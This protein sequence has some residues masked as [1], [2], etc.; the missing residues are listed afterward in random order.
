MMNGGGKSDSAIVAERPTNKAGQP[1]AEPED[2]RAETEGNAVQQSTRRGSEPGKRVPGAGSHTTSSKTEKEGKFT[3][4][5]HHI[6]PE[7]L[8]A[9]FFQL[10]ENAAPGVDGLTW[11]AYEEGLD[12]KILDLH[13]RLLRA[14]PSRRIYIPKPDG[15]QRPL[16]VAALEDKIVQRATI[17]V[18]NAIYEEGFLGFSYGFR[19]KRGQ[20]DALDAL[21]IGITI[22]KVNFVLD[23]DIRSYADPFPEAPD[24]RPAHNPPDPRSGS[25]RVSSKTGL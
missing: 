17:G 15:R 6:S 18:L 16:A 11:R 8:E 5:L 10:K 13:S 4:L 19:L 14:L 21:V 7:H 12:A 22:R 9:A 1:A 2:R 24:Q 3:A 25:R 20:H 23:A